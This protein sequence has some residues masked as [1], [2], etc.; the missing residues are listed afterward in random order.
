MLRSCPPRGP[1]ERFLPG[2][3]QLTAPKPLQRSPETSSSWPPAAARVVSGAGKQ[4][5][6]PGQVA[7]SSACLRR[8]RPLL[9]APF[10]RPLPPLASTRL[11][12]SSS[13]Y[14]SSHLTLQCSGRNW[15]NVTVEE[16][17][18]KLQ[19]KPSSGAFSFFNFHLFVY[20]CVFPFLAPPVIYGSTP[21]GD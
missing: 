18:S 1:S 10:P 16:I 17:H 11:F 4:G 2:K 15:F 12:I 3:L 20:I 5:S 13:P 19:M 7:A 14:F 21:A 9:P 8:P 6:R